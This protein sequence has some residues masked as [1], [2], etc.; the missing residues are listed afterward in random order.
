MF[1][2]MMRDAKPFSM[3]FNKRDRSGN[4]LIVL[5]NRQLCA[6]CS[7]LGVFPEEARLAHNREQ[8]MAVPQDDERQVIH[9]LEPGLLW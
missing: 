1:P 5:P 2:L 6:R 9:V 4:L 8:P 3:Q 7:W